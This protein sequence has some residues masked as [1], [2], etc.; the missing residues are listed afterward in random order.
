MDVNSPV[1]TP[2]VHTDVNVG[3]DTGSP[4]M[5]DCAEVTQQ[6]LTKFV[7]EQNVQT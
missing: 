2:R 1:L 7:L 5:A 6:L 3:E 4:R